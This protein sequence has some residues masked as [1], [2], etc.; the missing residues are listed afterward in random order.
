MVRFH[1][2][3]EY[4][5]ANPRLANDMQFEQIILFLSLTRRLYPAIDL[6]HPRS[7]QRL[8][9]LPQNIAALLASSLEIDEAMVQSCWTVLGDLAGRLPSEILPSVDAMLHERGP[10]YGL[11][12]GLDD[13]ED[14]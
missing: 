7:N 1:D 13:C 6:A 3:I 14:D 4:L 2:V 11:G 9:V 5:S 12:E 10:A 8:P